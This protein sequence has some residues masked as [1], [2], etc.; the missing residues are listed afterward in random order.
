MT[1]MNINTPVTIPT[2]G[3]LRAH[4]KILAGW[5][6]LAGLVWS[7]LAPY[8]MAFGVDNMIVTMGLGRCPERCQA[9]INVSGPPGGFFAVDLVR[10]TQ[11]TSGNRTF[12]D[13]PLKDKLYGYYPIKTG[14]YGLPIKMPQG[15]SFALQIEG[16]NR[17]HLLRGRDAGLAIRV[18][19]VADPNPSQAN[20]PLKPAQ[21][22]LTF[23]SSMFVRIDLDNASP[24]GAIKTIHL[25]TE[26]VAMTLFEK[27]SLTNTSALPLP[28]EIHGR[29]KDERQK[30]DK[31]TKLP[32][33]FASMIGSFLGGKK[34]RRLAV[35]PGST[36]FLYVPVAGHEGRRLKLLGVVQGGRRFA[37]PEIVIGLRAAPVVGPTPEPVK[38]PGFLSP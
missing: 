5:A 12:Q 19:Q 32:V 2:R 6:L 29:L 9:K 20:L 28:V 23:M 14:A 31:Q 8:A 10:M 3:T 34:D 26:V 21:A 36:V 37:S 11:D 27:F 13:I 18:R 4:A 30:I 1:I 7:A 33:L 24:S 15:G 16:T 22:Q 38:V 35:A 25:G 17:A